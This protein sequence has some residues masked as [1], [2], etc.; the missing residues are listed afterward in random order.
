MPRALY[1]LI[2]LA[3]AVHA[4]R[5]LRRA[6]HTHTPDA[7]YERYNL[8]MPAGVWLKRKFHLPMLIEINTPLAV[9]G[10]PRYEACSPCEPTR[11]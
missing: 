10:S 5:R 8:F 7:F 3:Y 9:C 2:E 11:G 4:Y 1:E 6:Y